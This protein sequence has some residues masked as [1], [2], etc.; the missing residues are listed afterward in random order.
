MNELLELEHDFGPQLRRALDLVIPTDEVSF[1]GQHAAEAK[2]DSSADLT[3][4]VDS[5]ERWSTSSSGRRCMVGVAAA[6]M[7]IGGLAAGLTLLQRDPSSTTESP[8]PATS[9]LGTT[10]SLVDPRSQPGVYLPTVTL[11][12]FSLA[13]ISVAQDGLERSIGGNGPD[14]DALTSNLHFAAD[15]PQPG[16]FVDVTTFVNNDPAVG[17]IEA[18][19]NQAGQTAGRAVVHHETAIV[20]TS[21]AGQFGPLVTVSWIENGYQIN[22]SGRAD[23][24]DL[25]AFAEGLA[26]S[27]LEQARQVRASLD[28][29]RFILPEVDRASLPN[30]FDIS[31]R[32]NGTGANVICL[33]APIQRCQ[34]FV[35]ESSLAGDFQRE[36]V[37]TFWI[38]DSPWFIGWSYGSHSPHYLVGGAAGDPIPNIA[39]T[40]SG[41]FFATELTDSDTQV[42]F[43]PTDPISIYAPGSGTNP[44]L[45]S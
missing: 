45:L 44:D 5:E 7:V 17:G 3:V 29:S 25:I 42:V 1:A 23:Q 2:L 13:D 6:V 40:E 12:G 22:I 37:G 27:S 18:G 26:P 15:N 14:A 43:D 19:F 21:P 20:A 36:V 4:T 31:I 10:P 8:E 39:Q 35:T 24:D 11:P 41:S 30:G 16:R 38:N 33:Q 9:A 34:L 28:E 32:T